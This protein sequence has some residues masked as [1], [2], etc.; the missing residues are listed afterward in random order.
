MSLLLYRL[1]AVAHRYRR[2]NTFGGGVR[3]D[4]TILNGRWPLAPAP[5]LPYYRG[6]LRLPRDEKDLSTNKGPRGE[7]PDEGA[8][9]STTG[10]SVLRRLLQLRSA[11]I[12]CLRY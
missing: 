9:V 10:I 12:L 8:N 1:H 3:I 11:P 6:P 4:K 2:D 7:R 5:L